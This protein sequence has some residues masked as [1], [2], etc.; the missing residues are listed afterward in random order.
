M[1]LSEPMGL[2][3]KKTTSP[4]QRQFRQVSTGRARTSAKAVK[5]KLTP[6]RKPEPAGLL[7]E[8]FGEDGE[9]QV[10]NFE[11]FNP[12]ARE[13]A[14]AGTFNGWRPEATPMKKHRGGRWSTGLLLAPGQYEYR[15]VVD[16]RWQDDPM[17]PRFVANP[18]GGLNCVVEVKTTA[19]PVTRRP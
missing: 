7:E 6:P 17:A 5:V 16:G 12:A 1:K 9:A 14:V 2:D 18:F 15:F 3:M 8:R 10:V 4:E 11:Y 19:L 13:V